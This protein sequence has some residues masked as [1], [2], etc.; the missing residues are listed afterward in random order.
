MR[1][2]LDNWKRNSDIKSE[3]HMFISVEVF[4]SSKEYLLGGK[5]YSELTKS[6]IGSLFGTLKLI[7]NFIPNCHCTSKTSRNSML[8]LM[9]A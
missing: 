4:S 2:K 3:P 7:T 9:G 5:F 6:N 1:A 8:T